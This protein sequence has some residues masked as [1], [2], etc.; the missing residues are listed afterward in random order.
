MARRK[1]HREE[2]LPFVALMDTMTNV[3]GVLIIVLVM[4]GIGL[5]KSVRKVLSDLPPVTVEEHAKLKKEV[6]ETAPK[7]DPR[8]VDEENTRLH[9]Q[10]KTASETLQTMDV[11]MEKQPVKLI[12]L[13]ELKAQLDARKKER[14]EKKANAEKLLAELDKLKAQL[15]TT[16]VVQP[17]PA[18]AVKLPNP[19]PMPEKAD[20][21]HFLVAGGRIVFINDEDFL[22]RV[23]AELKKSES[24]LAPVRETVKDANGNP[25]MQAEKSGRLTPV[26]R[27]VFDPKKLIDYLARARLDTREIKVEIPLSP[28]SPNIPVKLTAQPGAGETVDQAKNLLS[29]FQNLLRK[30]KADSKSVIW[31]HVYKDSIPTY[32]AARDLVDQIGVPVG[33]DIYDAPSFVRYVPPEYTVNFT[34]P[35]AP[36]GPPPAVTIA[37]PKATLD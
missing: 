36:T 31:F 11:T 6:E 9:E 4:I 22:K 32:L 15:D 20:I 21:R 33:W 34:P 29:V 24:T 37:P 3:V 13:D 30:F 12:N 5:A 25:V 7:H 27:V 26:R 16:P 10:L 8:Q 35:P 19:R 17:P 23:E 18:I 1:G 28:N 14:D 2:E